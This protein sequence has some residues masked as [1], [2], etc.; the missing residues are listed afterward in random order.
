LYYH[1]PVRRHTLTSAFDIRKLGSELPRV[2]VVV[3]YSGVDGAM[4]D[5]CV[6]AGARGIVSAGTGA[7]RPTPAEDA[8]LDAARALG[9]VVCQA[10]RTG[11]GRVARSPRLRSRGFVTADNLTPWKARVLLA[12]ALT[13]SDDPDFIQSLFDTH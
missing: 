9:V 2:D 1:T 6:S 11:S 10:S 8:A 13:V 12:L 7:G 3:S 4:I 5:A